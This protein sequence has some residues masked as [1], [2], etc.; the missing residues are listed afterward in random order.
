MA[1]HV[2]DLAE[3]AL[4]GDTS[5]IDDPAGVRIVARHVARPHD[6]IEPSLGPFCFAPFEFDPQTGELR[7]HGLR[8]KLH[9]QPIKVL[10][11]LLQ[12]PAEVVTREELQKRLWAA[13]TYVDFEHSLNSA[14][15][16]LRAALGD[17][18]DAP[19]FIE[20][21]ARRGYRFSAPLANL[22]KRFLL[23]LRLRLPR[24]RSRQSGRVG[25]CRLPRW[26]LASP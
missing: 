19:R 17:S 9:G 24:S 5:D 13:D 6:E 3:L 23:C 4:S 22:R 16:R 18:G 10:T 15:K 12:H 26:R 20:T 1:P 2:D 21:I 7:K 25:L 11:M 8:I 14:M